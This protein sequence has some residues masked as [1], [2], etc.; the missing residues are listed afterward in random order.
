MINSIIESISIA[1]N[2]EFGDD[3]TIYSESV[4]QGLKEPCFFVF[5]LNPTT[6]L[7]L[8]KRYFRKN[9][10]CVQFIP[11]DKDRV[12]EECNAVAERLFSCLEY[13][14]VTGDL[15]QGTQMNYEIVDGILNFFVNYDLFVY[16]I[17][18]PD[19]MEE[20]IQTETKAKG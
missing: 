8:G 11:G 14:T 5:C 16:K 17:I 13:I 15:V 3:Y 10:F 9:P 18:K 6:K 19:L 4:E 12:K 2:A 1:L 7:F 20:L